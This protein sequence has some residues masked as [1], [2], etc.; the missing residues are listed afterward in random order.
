MNVSINTILYHLVFRLYIVNNNEEQIIPG[1]HIDG[2]TVQGGSGSYRW[3]AYKTTLLLREASGSLDCI[4]G[5]Q[6]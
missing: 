4:V 5:D 2:A 6:N 1:Y 3:F